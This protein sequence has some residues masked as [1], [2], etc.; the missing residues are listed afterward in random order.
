MRFSVFT[1]NDKDITLRGVFFL[2]FSCVPPYSRPTKERSDG[3]VFFLSFQAYRSKSNKYKYIDDIN[4]SFDKKV[5]KNKISIKEAEHYAWCI[6]ERKI[7]Y[8]AEL[9]S[10][11]IGCKAAI[12]ISL[13]GENGCFDLNKCSLDSLSYIFIDNEYEDFAVI[14]DTPILVSALN[15]HYPLN[16]E[17]C[18]I[19]SSLVAKT[20]F[21][22]FSAGVKDICLQIERKMKNPVMSYS[23]LQ[24]VLNANNSLDSLADEMNRLKVQVNGVADFGFR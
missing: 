11:S 9:F 3:M 16:I 10:L 5:A 4:H 20:P 15:P 18:G 13:F 21:E 14:L 12:Y 2:D 23:T 19:M 24:A 17:F 7:Y 22:L 8:Q 6:D 1:N